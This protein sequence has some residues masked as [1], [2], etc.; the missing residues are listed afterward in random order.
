MLASMTPRQ[1]SEWLEYYSL[2]PWGDDW[3]Q[4]GVI[5]STVKNNIVMALCANGGE[6]VK[7]SDLSDP[8]DFVPNRKKPKKKKS[9][10]AN[11]QESLSVLRSR[12][13]V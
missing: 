7:Q 2:Q 13:G 8:E 12:I 10:K 4:T 1:F 9:M 6:K 5:A 3:L 11:L